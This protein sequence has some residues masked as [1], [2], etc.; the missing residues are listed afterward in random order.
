ML[1]LSGLDLW[2]VGGVRRIRRV[3]EGM[4]WVVKW[5]VRASTGLDSGP[6][7]RRE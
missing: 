1:I 7:W 6:A 4:V 2:K 5:V 3:D